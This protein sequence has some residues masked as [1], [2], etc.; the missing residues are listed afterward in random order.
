MSDLSQFASCRGLRRLY[1]SRAD[2][3]MV[4][5]QGLMPRLEVKEGREEW[6]DARTL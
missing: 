2:A 4:P 6:L 3:F 5:L 1:T